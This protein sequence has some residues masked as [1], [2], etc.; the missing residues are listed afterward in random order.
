MAPVVELPLSVP[1][2]VP[3]L[4]VD[5]ADDP[6]EGAGATVVLGAVVTGAALEPVVVGVLL[7]GSVLWSSPLQ[8][9]N[10]ATVA[11][12]DATAKS[13]ARYELVTPRTY[14]SN[15]ASKPV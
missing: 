3:P 5:G 14:P 12:A 2:P 10:R 1:P 6:P 15:N 9:D 8:P 13:A 7:L 4:A 11:A